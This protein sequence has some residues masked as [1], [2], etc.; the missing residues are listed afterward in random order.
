MTYGCQFPATFTAVQVIVFPLV[1]W[2]LVQG[3]LANVTYL[4]ALVKPNPFIVSKEAPLVWV[5]KEKL[6]ICAVGEM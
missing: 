4:S 5:D 2:K 6:V 3:S 1:T